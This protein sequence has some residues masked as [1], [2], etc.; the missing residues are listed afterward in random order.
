M[1]VYGTLTTIVR[2]SK[3]SIE[4][5]IYTIKNVKI[6]QETSFPFEE[7]TKLTVTKGTANFRLMI[8]YPEWVSEG[9]MKITVNGEKFEGNQITWTIHGK[10]YQQQDL[11]NHSD[12]HW[13]PLEPAIFTVKKP[14]GLKLG[15]YDVEIAFGYSQSYIP[16]VDWSRISTYNRKMTLAG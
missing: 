5:T 16:S 15:M 12:V 2:P 1:G 6:E 11:P 4:D 13:S 9:A 14:G 8:R 10:T 3:Y 7:Q